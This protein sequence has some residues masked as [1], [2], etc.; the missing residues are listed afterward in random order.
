MKTRKE[1]AFVM[2][3]NAT[4]VVTYRRGTIAAANI[5]LATIH[6]SKRLRADGSAVAAAAAANAG[7]VV[8]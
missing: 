4:I 2:A 5:T 7:T 3:S 1:V 6:H 8:G